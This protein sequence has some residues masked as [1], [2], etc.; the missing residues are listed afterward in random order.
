MSN[1][2]EYFQQRRREAFNLPNEKF[3]KGWTEE[4]WI[5]VGRHVDPLTG[6]IV[7]HSYADYCDD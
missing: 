7:Y 6:T 2:Q 4:E 3:K 1:D 5:K